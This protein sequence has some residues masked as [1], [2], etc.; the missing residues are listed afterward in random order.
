ME[1]LV[2][3]AE[4]S[5]AV[6]EEVETHCQEVIGL[7]DKKLI[8]IAEVIQRCVYVGVRGRKGLGGD[9]IDVIWPTPN[10]RR[11]TM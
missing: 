2:K 7:L 3:L 9:G 5:Q 6:A 10:Y 1:T 11:E 4:D 8:R